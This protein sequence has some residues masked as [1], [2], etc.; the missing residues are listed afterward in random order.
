MSQK[1]ESRKKYLAYGSNLNL[2]QMARRCPTAK[3]VGKGEIKDHE[4]LFRG[5][6][7]SAVATVEP[8]AGS[9]VPVLIWELGRDDERNLDV[10]EGYPRLY[11][12]VDLVVQTEEGCESIMAYTMNEGHELG[13][14]SDHYL[15]IIME[16]YES[17]GF[18][19]DG[20]LASVDHCKEL[21]EM[22]QGCGTGREENG[23]TQQL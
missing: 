10:Y 16:G 22:Q 3:V 20:L 8:K 2:E 19:V 5:Y 14:P 11:G 23:W 6:R 7:N 15:E 12:K 21:L 4:L 18:D 9:S 1:R 13:I 17:A